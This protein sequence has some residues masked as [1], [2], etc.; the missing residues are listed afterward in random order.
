MSQEMEGQ[1]SVDEH[2]NRAYLK[3]GSFMSPHA[4]RPHFNG[5]G[6]A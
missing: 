6:A 5:D 4:L 2:K 3:S 1:P